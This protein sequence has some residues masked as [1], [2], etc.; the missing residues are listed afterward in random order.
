MVFLSDPNQSSKHME[1]MIAD[2]RVALICLS[3]CV[4]FQFVEDLYCYALTQKDNRRCFRFP[5]WTPIFTSTHPTVIQIRGMSKSFL[6]T[7]YESSSL[8][9]RL[10]FDFLLATTIIHELTHAFGIMRRGDLKEPFYHLS[11]PQAELGW[12]WEEFALG[13]IFNPFDRA[14]ARISFLMRK[15]WLSD[16]VAYG[17]GGKEWTAVPMSWIAQW[18]QISTW[19]K[20]AKDGPRVID[21]PSSGLRIRCSGEGYFTIFA[22]NSSAIKDIQKL[23]MKVATLACHLPMPTAAHAIMS[24]T[25]V[26]TANKPTK[27]TRDK[28]PNI[29]SMTCRVAEVVDRVGNSA[30]VELA[31][32]PIPVKVLKR[33]LPTNVDD[34]DIDSQKFETHPRRKRVKV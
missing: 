18:F 30:A 9:D 34:S 1:E 31:V 22:D 23:K 24:T 33:P 20:I 25:T 2:V 19:S 15:V 11:D 21:P 14:S 8:C 17:S 5:H 10:R 29:V 13:G 12:S 7:D 6:E 26:Q 16:E 32:A 3:Y 27:I 4:Q 28:N